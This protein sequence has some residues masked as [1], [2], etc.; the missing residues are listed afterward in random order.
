MRFDR[1]GSALLTLTGVVVEKVSPGKNKLQ[2]P[3]AQAAQTD[4]EISRLQ[5]EFC[6]PVAWEIGRPVRYIVH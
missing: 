4:H 3:Q 5:T 2:S 1:P 6:A